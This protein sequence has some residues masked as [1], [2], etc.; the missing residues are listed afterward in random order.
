MLCEN[1]AS[2]SDYCLWVMQEQLWTG[3]NPYSE[4]NELFTTYIDNKPLYIKVELMKE[5]FVEGFGGGLRTKL[6]GYFIRGDLAWGVEEWKIQKPI[7]YLL[8]QH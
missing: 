3:W 2:D 8:T 5:P 6:F 7:F 4:S 1:F